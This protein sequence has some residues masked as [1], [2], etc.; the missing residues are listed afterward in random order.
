MSKNS[1]LILNNK[2]NPIIAYSSDEFK[3]QIEEKKAK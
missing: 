3:S 2:I 1:K